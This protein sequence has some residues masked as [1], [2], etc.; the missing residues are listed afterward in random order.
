MMSDLNSLVAAEEEVIIDLAALDAGTLLIISKNFSLS[1]NSFSPKN[2]AGTEED[3]NIR[4][5][6]QHA[7]DYLRQNDMPRA[8]VSGLL[9]NTTPKTRLI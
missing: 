5:V 1:L 4:K 3:P 8:P 6:N 7:A 9:L 2:K